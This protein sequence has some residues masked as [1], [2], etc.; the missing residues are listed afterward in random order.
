M[1]ATPIRALIGLGNPGLEYLRT[2]HNAGFWL[3]DALVAGARTQFRSE[4]KFQGELAKV[5]V[6]THEL[7]VLKPSTYMN[8]SGEAVQ[9]LAQFYKIAAQEILVVHDELDL[10]PGV[11]RLKSGG[12]HGGHNGLR[13]LHQHLGPDYLR[14]RIGVGHPGHKDQV[15]DYLTSGRP[16][17]A[18]E[19]LI[20]DSIANALQVLPVL[21]SQGLERA[22][23]LLHSKPDA[24]ATDE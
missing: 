15:H 3:V 19:T 18:E 20:L 10:P 2:R 13:S 1:S 4:V 9:K 12:G 7:L 17:K 6:G 14:L 8:R 24:G 21:F 5:S 16:R 22:M 23:L 11:A